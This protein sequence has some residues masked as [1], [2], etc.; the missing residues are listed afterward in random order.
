MSALFVFDLRR[1]IKVDTFV[2]HKKEGFI[3]KNI[4]M[5]FHVFDMDDFDGVAISAEKPEAAAACGRMW[6]KRAKK[7]AES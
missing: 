1:H 7:E 5:V 6:W 3:M 2:A 4:Y